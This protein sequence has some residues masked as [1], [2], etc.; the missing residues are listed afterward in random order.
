MI[1][2]SVEDLKSSMY[3]NPAPQ[4]SACLAF[5]AANNWKKMKKEREK[6]KEMII[7]IEWDPSIILEYRLIWNINNI[8]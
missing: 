3:P 8:L 2:Q 7:K 1:R 4:K 5:V 6:I